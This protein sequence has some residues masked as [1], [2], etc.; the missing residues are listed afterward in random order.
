M[1]V[2]LCFVELDASYAGNENGRLARIGIPEQGLRSPP[3][4]RGAM[5][6]FVESEA[7]R[8]EHAA[9]WL[10]ANTPPHFLADGAQFR[11]PG[12]DEVRQWERALYEAGLAAVSWPV[13]YGGQ[14]GTM[15]GHLAVSKEI[16]RRA[17]PESVNSIGKEIVGAILLGLGN[18]V[19]KCTYLPRIARMDDIWS[20]AFSEPQAGSDLAAVT[21]T[22]RADG[23]DWRISGQKIWTSYADRASFCLLLARTGDPVQR[24][25]NLTLI[26]VP[27]DAPGITVR[28]IRQIDGSAEFNEVFF[29]DVVVPM[30]GTVGEIGRGWQ[31]AMSVLTVERATNRMYR[32]WRFENE[33]R[34]LYAVAGHD[35]VDFQRKIAGFA[36]DARIVQRYAEEIAARVCDDRPLETLG[37]LMKLHWSEAH[38]R[39]ASFAIETLG[40]E[41]PGEPATVA[42]ARRRFEAIYWRSRSE[43]LIAGTSEVQRSII[44]DRELRLARAA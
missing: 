3:K 34:H 11:E 19:Q 25:K 26:I 6:H 9:R 38:Q 40:S 15:L 7:A 35:G 37:N 43:T 22:A 13:E 12:L 2:L 23:A 14:G 1:E 5:N 8:A 36:I 27:L 20:Q 10:E 30:S 44:A 18:E 31:G 24:Y 41:R 39:F 4:Q 42:T 16:G 29:D 33:V 21:T 32:G 28:P 17:L